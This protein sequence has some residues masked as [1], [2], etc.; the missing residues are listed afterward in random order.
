MA[1]KEKALIDCLLFPKYAGGIKEI[2]KAI[3]SSIK[4]L[5]RKK[6]IDYALRVESRVVIR[7]L[8]FLLEEFQFKDSKILKKNIGAGYELL[9]PTL[10]KKNNLNKKWLLDINL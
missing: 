9:D 6:L 3:L 4:S 2:R 10:K 5:D 1:E 7:R 8:G